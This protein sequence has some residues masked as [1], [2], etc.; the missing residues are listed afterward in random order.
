MRVLGLVTPNRTVGWPGP[1]LLSRR[2]PLLAF[3]P[4][5]PVHPLLVHQPAFPPQQAVSHPPAPADV[6]G[7][8]LAET[9]PQLSHL[10]RDDLGRMALGAA[11][12]THHT[13]GEPLGNP[14]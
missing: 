12:L 11:V 7:S 10:D 13:A 3:L 9:M 1:L 14:E 2:W 4:P 5:E 8:D 6:L